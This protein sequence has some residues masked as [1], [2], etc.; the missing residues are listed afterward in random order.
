MNVYMKQHPRCEGRES[1]AGRLTSVDDIVVVNVVLEGIVLG[2]IHDE[3]VSEFLVAFNEGREVEVLLVLSD[4]LQSV[5]HL[6][7]RTWVSRNV[8]TDE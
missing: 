1:A 7:K 2:G 3:D 5:A 8:P 4:L 6:H